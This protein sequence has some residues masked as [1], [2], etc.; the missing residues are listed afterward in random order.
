MLLLYEDINGIHSVNIN[1]IKNEITR[2]LSWWGLPKRQKWNLT[3][4]YGIYLNSQ[5][6][7][8]GRKLLHLDKSPL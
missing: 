6:R 3:Y 5:E 2:W 4:T 7:R 1:R 8:Y